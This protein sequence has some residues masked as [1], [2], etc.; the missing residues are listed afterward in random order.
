MINLKTVVANS[1]K[2]FSRSV[3]PYDF[4]RTSKRIDMV[5]ISPNL[6]TIATALF[7]ADG[8]ILNFCL[9]I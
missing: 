2:L 4:Y 6:A 3:V 1:E 5:S 8:A 9:V 7:G